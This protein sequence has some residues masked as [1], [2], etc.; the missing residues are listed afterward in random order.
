MTMDMYR[1]RN[2]G[3][4]SDLFFNFVNYV[5]LILKLTWEL[6]CIYAWPMDADSAMVK[7]WEG[8]VRGV[9]GSM[10]KK[11]KWISVTISTI[12]INAKNY[13]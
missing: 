9:G 3:I 6:T 8:Q 7:A 13:L 11:T 10:G 5:S 4:G 2:K 1:K 12:K